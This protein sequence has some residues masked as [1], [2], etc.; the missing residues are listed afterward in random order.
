MLT[1]PEKANLGADR[2]RDRRF[3]QLP[4]VCG[5]PESQLLFAQGSLRRI[6]L[7]KTD[8]AVRRS[9]VKKWTC[10]RPRRSRQRLATHTGYADGDRAKEPLQKPLASDRDIMRSRG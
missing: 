10:P 5:S 6:G 9:I 2:L 1:H 4:A 7:R 8:V 3:R